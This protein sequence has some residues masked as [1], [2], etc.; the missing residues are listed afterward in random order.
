MEK[1]VPIKRIE[2][3]KPLSRDHHHALLL[4][5]KIKTGFTKN[6][7]AERIKKYCDWIYSQEITPHFKEEEEFIYPVL[8]NDNTMVIRALKEHRELR[9]LFESKVNLKVNLVTIAGKLQE[10]IR[11]EERELF[12]AVQDAATPKQIEYITDNTHE[13]KFVDDLSDPFWE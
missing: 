6:V 2:A 7:A 10:H 8:G 11:F 5:W 3:L 9:N 1:I 12:N 4:C 13:I